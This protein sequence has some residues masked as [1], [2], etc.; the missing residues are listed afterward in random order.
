MFLRIEVFFYGMVGRINL[1]CVSF[2]L[3]LEVVVPFLRVKEIFKSQAHH[4]LKQ[5]SKQSFETLI[6]QHC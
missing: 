2:D 6:F 4:I 3:K 1:E 5:T